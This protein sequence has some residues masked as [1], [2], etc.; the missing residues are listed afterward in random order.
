MSDSYKN[1]FEF[2]A[3]I[4]QMAGKNMWMN[5]ERRNGGKCVC[6]FNDSDNN[7]SSMCPHFVVD[8]CA[9][10]DRQCTLILTCGRHLSRVVEIVE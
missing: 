5:L 8:S 4:K 2:V 3:R 7:C 9:I 1:G 6:P 10:L